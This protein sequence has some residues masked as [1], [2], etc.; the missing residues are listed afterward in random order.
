MHPYGLE[1]VLLVMAM[2]HLPS[3]SLRFSSIQSQAIA[4]AP[5]SSQS[6]WAD[7]DHQHLQYEAWRMASSSFCLL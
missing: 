4:A 2:G 1:K 6:Q 3:C 7:A 5:P